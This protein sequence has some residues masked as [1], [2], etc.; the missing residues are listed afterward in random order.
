MA[1]NLDLEEQEQLDQLKHFWNRWGNLITWVMIVILGSYAAWNGWG[2]WQKRNA[3]QAAVLYDT[4]EQA[5]KGTDLGL[6][7]RSL[8]EIQ[9]RYASATMAHHAALLAANRFEVQS[10][11]AK[12]LAALTWVTKQADDEG[13]V[14]LALWRLA[15]LQMEAKDWAAAQ[16]SLNQ[17]KVP[18]P[19]QPLFDERL[20]DLQALQSQPDAAKQSYLKSWRAADAGSDQR[21]WL[22][23][24]LA[25]MGVD[26]KEK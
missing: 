19:F 24:K 11:P 23:I 2:W 18:A 15:G 17:R 25:A 3:S 1:S 10:E 4:V 14:A 21:R 16:N 12:A 5:A 20:G 26:P 7:E 22:E 13:L 6:L 8:G 9:N